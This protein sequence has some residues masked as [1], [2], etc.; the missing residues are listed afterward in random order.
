M[1]QKLLRQFGEHGN[2][3]SPVEVGDKINEILDMLY[4]TC[5]S[6]DKNVYEKGYETIA[7]EKVTEGKAKTATEAIEITA[8]PPTRSYAVRSQ[9]TADKVYLIKDGK[10][11]WIKNPETLAKLGFKFSD[12]KS[13]T[14]EEMA[15]F[16]TGEPINLKEAVISEVLQPK[17][18]ADKYNL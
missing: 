6:S 10:K 13:I 15:K 4:N 17:D 1:I 2:E 9:S 14:N 3:Y 5:W 11:Y 16:E 8:V 18:D 12:I 7:M